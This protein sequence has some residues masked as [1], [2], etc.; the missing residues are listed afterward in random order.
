[1]ACSSSTLQQSR[2]KHRNL[3]LFVGGPLWY[4]GA[5][6][7]PRHDPFFEQLEADLREGVEAANRG[8]TIPAEDV[9]RRFGLQPEDQA[10]SVAE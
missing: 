7:Q 1:M 6:Q 2:R 10:D 9:W 3:T 8:E 5:M 4:A